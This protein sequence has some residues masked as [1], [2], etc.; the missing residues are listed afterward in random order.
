MEI[1][2]E[3]KSLEL[4]QFVSRY[5]TSMFLGDISSLMNFIS[6]DNPTNSL[7]GLSSPL[8]QLYYLAGLNLTSAIDKTTALIPQYSNED[9]EHIKDL[10]NQIEFGYQH[11]FYPKQPDEVNEEWVMKRMIAMP[12]FLSYF[13]QGPLN[14]EEQVIERVAIYFQ[15]FNNEIKQHFGLEVQDFIDI[16]NYIDSLPNKFL[17]EK[18]NYKEGQQTWEEFAGE[19][20]SKNIL[21]PDWNNYMPEHFKNLF[22]FMYDK[23]SMNRFTEVELA[24]QFG[25]DKA[26]AFITTLTCERRESN[27]LYYSENNILHTKPLFKVAEDSYQTI[28]T[29]QLIHAV[30]NSLF[31]FCK[32]LP[33]KGEKFYAVRGSELETKIEKIFQNFFKGKAF[34]YKGFFTQDKHEQDLLFLIDGLALIVEA[35]ASKRDEPRRDPEKA[36]PLILS[37]FN[38][39]IQKG[40]DQAYRVKSKFIN[41]EVLQIYKDQ[42]LKKHIIDIRTKN[43]HHAFSIVVTL[44]RFGQI[45]TNL[46]ELLEI[47]DDDDFPWSVTV[48]DLEVFLL[49]LKKLSKKTSDLTNYLIM[50]EKLHGRLIC[51]DELETCGGFL[52]NKITNEHLNTDQTVALTPDLSGIFDNYY[53]KGGIGFAN[54][55][56]MNL[57]TDDK[58]HVIG[59]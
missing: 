25:N 13:N 36:Y 2:L 57:K 3:Q 48:D 26:S 24:N 23:G 18:I 41:H 54:E 4:K 53:H 50:R 19:M 27:F 21:L 39:T 16:Y 37:N 22:Q 5:E 28:E 49:L 8:R 32:T 38:E 15:P 9:W 46:A 14:Y 40:Y 55:K 45:Q 12:T 10:L 35:K 30:Y 1:N 52:T 51:G 6:F 47:Y 34:V 20:I 31:E 58:Y 42:D 33:D 29:K 59:Q 43:Y 11:F 56:N 7:K 44:E 17:G